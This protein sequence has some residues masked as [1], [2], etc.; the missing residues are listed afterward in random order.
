MKND[1][2]FLKPIFVGGC[3]RSGTTFLAASLS[4]LPGVIA[5]PES[6]FIQE[7]ADR[8][9]ASGD[10]VEGM[11]EAIAAHPRYDAWRKAG[12]REP[13]DIAG[14]AP[15]Q[16]SALDLLIRHYAETCGWPAPVAFVEHAPPNIHHAHALRAQFPDLFLFHIHRDGRAVAASWIPL[17]WGPVEIIEMARVWPAEIAAG[18]AAVAELGADHARNVSY[19]HLVTGGD[20]TLAALAK[21]L[22]VEDAAEEAPKFLRPA[23]SKDIHR[24]VGGGADAS[25]IEAWREKLSA[26]EIEIFEAMA[27]ETL[28]RLGYARAAGSAPS[29]P[30]AFERFRGA[31]TRRLR[32][33]Q[34][35]KRFNERQLQ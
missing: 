32:Y 5:L 14:D 12:C 20:E 6:H 1:R 18:E 33:K 17:D 25:R 11:I 4:R 34:N 10:D 19:E 15:D 16:R 23:Y 24:L 7:A 28:D 13:G 22:G 8:R 26:R 27:G 3:D 29:A 30:S 35:I 31:I 2:Q 21:I 9:L